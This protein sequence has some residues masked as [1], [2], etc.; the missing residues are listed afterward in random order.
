M[1]R[2]LTRCL[3]LGLA[4]LPAQAKA[5]P[6][7]PA[8][9][10]AGVPAVVLPADDKACPTLLSTD[11]CS[12]PAVKCDDQCPAER[13]RSRFK[14]SFEYLYWS[15]HDSNVAYGQQFFGNDPATSVPR[16]PV[17]SVSPR[18]SS[19]VR[20]GVGAAVSDCGWVVG[21]YTDFHDTATSSVRAVDPFVI[22]SLLNLPNTTNAMVQ[23]LQ[24]QA[25]MSIDLQTADLEYQWLFC[26]TDHLNLTFLAGARFG[27]IDQKMLAAYEVTGT[28]V[29]NPLV[30]FDGGGP[31]LGLEGEYKIN[32]GFYGYT[33]GAVNLLAGEFTGTYAQY[34]TFTGFVGATFIRDDR[35]VPVTELELGFGWQSCTGRVKLSGGY[36]VG[37]WF[38]TMTI[39]SLATSVQTVN[40]TRNANNNKDVMT[41]D[42]LVGRLELSF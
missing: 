28:T 36:Y 38:N 2:F 40:F 39:G 25:A 12:A 4:V 15:V 30:N 22:R 19:G 9:P 18:Y 35:L 37:S 13:D 14:G 21:T 20:L 7:K 11:S 6:P 8:K 10:D 5:D 1:K 24:A 3:V 17:D 27:H 42:G 16:G 33:K 34:N 23:S 31:R 29:I 41:F 26:H 32:G